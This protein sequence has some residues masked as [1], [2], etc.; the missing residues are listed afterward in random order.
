MAD[1]KWSRK[2]KKCK[3]CGTIST[4]HYQ[5]GYCLTCWNT[6]VHKKYKKYYQLYYQRYWKKNKEKIKAKRLEKALCQQQYD[7]SE[8]K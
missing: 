5:H 3:K 6:I 8:R 4:P 7:I 2:Y 1:K